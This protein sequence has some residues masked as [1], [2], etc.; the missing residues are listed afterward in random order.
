MK[1]K[2]GFLIISCDYTFCVITLET[3]AVSWVNVQRKEIYDFAIM[4]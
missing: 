4:I 3:D 2:S 1:Y